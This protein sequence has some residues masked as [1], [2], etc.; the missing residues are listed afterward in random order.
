MF[1][2][3]LFLIKLFLPIKKKKLVY[4][5]MLIS[6]WSLKKQEMSQIKQQKCLGTR[7]LNVIF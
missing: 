5:T 4:L 2:Y 1:S 3:N 6:F 7:K